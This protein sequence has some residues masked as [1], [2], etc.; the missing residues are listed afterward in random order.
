MSYDVSIIGILD[1]EE[2]S[3]RLELVLERDRNEIPKLALRFATYSEGLGWIVQKTIQIDSKQAEEM[4]FLLGGARHLLKQAAQNAEIS[5]QTK[6][7]ERKH[8]GRIVDFSP[9]IRKSA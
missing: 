5:Q 4:Q 7:N 3:R 8:T 1:S 9:A 6:I 2:E